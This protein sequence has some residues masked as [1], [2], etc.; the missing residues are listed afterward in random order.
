MVDLKDKKQGF[1]VFEL[2]IVI[3][4]ASGL[5]T[6][7]SLIYH[8]GTKSWGSGYKRYILKKELSRTLESMSRDL[9]GASRIGAYKGIYT[10]EYDIKGGSTTTTYCYYLYSPD[11]S[12]DW[13]I[14]PNKVY[15]LK[16][17]LVSEATTVKRLLWWWDSWSFKT[18]IRPQIE[19]YGDGVVLLNNIVSPATSDSTTDLRYT[20]D[21]MVVIDFLANA[22]SESVRMRTEIRPR[23]VL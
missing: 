12:S 14:E 18:K 5:M 9:R 23:N 17:A 3:V 4:L 13:A 8:G 15:Q 20:N 19:N 6:I 22:D 10:I 7:I 16:G 2:L 11:A 21:G 1:S